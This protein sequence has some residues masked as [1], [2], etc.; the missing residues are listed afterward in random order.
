MST[1]QHKIGSGFGATSTADDVLH[2][3]DLGGKLALV[4]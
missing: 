2:G 4:T 1:A 3:I